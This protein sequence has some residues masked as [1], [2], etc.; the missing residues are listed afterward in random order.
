MAIK[1]PKEKT[2]KSAYS[3]MIDDLVNKAINREPFQY[4]PATDQAYQAYAREYGRL[5]NEA[6]QNTLADVASNTG[7]L[8]SSYATTAAAQARGEYNQKLTNMIPS[9]MEAA[10]AKYRDQYNDALSGINVLQGLDDSAYNR[11]NTD[12]QYNRGIYESDR[13]YARSV[14]END[15]Q[16][17]ESVRQYNQNYDL[18]KNSAEF[19]RMLNTWST[20]GYATKKIAKY[21]GVKEGTKTN[22][23]AYQAAQLALQRANRSSGGGGGGRRGRSGGRG[24][25]GSNGG[26]NGEELYGKYYDAPDNDFYNDNLYRQALNIASQKYNN[27]ASYEQIINYLDTL[28]L[29]QDERDRIEKALGIQDSGYTSQGIQRNQGGNKR[30][31]M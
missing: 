25:Y 16:F 3:S 19:E 27:G 20:L 28:D 30:Q 29:T 23:A 6:A 4:D 31:V 17:N 8:A 13:D 2:Y 12:R 18:D 14:L 11:F 5:G 10:Y 26:Y 22:E 7:G 1:A 15:R 24:S 21:F 9:L